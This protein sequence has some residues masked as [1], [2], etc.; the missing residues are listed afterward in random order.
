MLTGL[1]EPG[2]GGPELHRPSLGVVREG[3]GEGLAA[4]K[5]FIGAVPPANGILPEFPTEINVLVFQDGRKIHQPNLQIL[6]DA[7][8][9]LNLLEGGANRLAGPVAV[10][11]PARGLLVI[12]NDAAGH[13]NLLSETAQFDFKLFHL[14]LLLDRLLEPPADL[15][16]EFLG[17]LAIEEALRR[18]FLLKFLL[19]VSHLV[20]PQA[21]SSIRARATRAQCLSSSGTSI[22]FTTRPSTRFSS[23]QQ[24]C[25]G[26]MRN[27]VVHTQTFGS[28]E[29]TSRSGHSLLS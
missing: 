19:V 24:R 3:R 22:R 29:M 12:Q 23:A 14:L 17:L 2:S 27:I 25:C 6:H 7:A 10:H 4:G 13:Q 11:L 5:T 9:L 20:S 15:R 8:R 21:F 26:V 16:Q 1:H 28:S 18:R